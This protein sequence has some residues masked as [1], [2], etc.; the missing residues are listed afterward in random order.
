MKK[1]FQLE[2]DMPDNHLCPGITGRINYLNE[3]YDILQADNDRKAG[4]R[5]KGIDVGTGASCIY[6]LLGNALYDWSFIATDIDSESIA[7]AQNL[8]KLNRL[9]DSIHCI[10]RDKRDFLIKD[11]IDP[12]IHFTM[13]NPPFFNTMDEV[14][15]IAHNQ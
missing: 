6:P 13:C 8:V 4:G 11:L 7:N 14:G 12:S 10:Q 2:W 3:I 1:D 9:E 15:F 5:I